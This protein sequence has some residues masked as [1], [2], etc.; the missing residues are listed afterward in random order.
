M[1]LVR[2][3]K[4]YEELVSC[5]IDVLVL[6]VYEV[7]VD[8]AKVVKEDTGAYKSLKMTKISSK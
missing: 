2:K 7:K 6:A 3:Y 1:K 5:P 8:D 4:F